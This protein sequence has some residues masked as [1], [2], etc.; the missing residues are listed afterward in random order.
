MGLLAGRR[1][2]HCEHIQ[3]TGRAPGVGKL[4]RTV[5]CPLPLIPCSAVALRNNLPERW[6]EEPLPL[7]EPELWSQ[8]ITYLPGLKTIGDSKTIWGRRSGIEPGPSPDMPMK[9]S[10]MALHA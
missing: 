5:L 3:M 1:A 8:S 2:H 4:K 7:H 9:C 6:I 10:T